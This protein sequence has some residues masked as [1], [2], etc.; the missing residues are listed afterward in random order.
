MQPELK[1]NK[2]K[3]LK[4][5]DEMSQRGN[6]RG[7]GLFDRLRTNVRFFT[8]YDTKISLKSCFW[9]KNV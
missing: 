4:T 7:Y 2:K 1:K 3:H 6:M 9:H 8:S 5:P